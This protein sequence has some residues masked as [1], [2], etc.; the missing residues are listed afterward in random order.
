MLS[1]LEL[2]LT[3][4]SVPAAALEEPG[5]DV[6][7]LRDMLTAATR[8][9]DHGKLTPWRLILF[10]GA[11]RSNDRCSLVLRTQN[12]QSGRYRPGAMSRE[13]EGFQAPYLRP[14]R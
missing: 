6:A 13:P 11:A 3:R 2:L 12:P 8:V 5:P 14:D 7:A 9:P 1:A 10:R 4:R